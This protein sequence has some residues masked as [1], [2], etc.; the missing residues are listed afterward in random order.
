MF[1]EKCHDGKKYFAVFVIE[2]SKSTSMLS[3]L[4]GRKEDRIAQVERDYGA[5]AKG[6]GWLS[7]RK[8]SRTRAII[9]QAGV[10]D[11]I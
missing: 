6:R 8:L 7:T 3:T 4:I 10:N 1:E 2:A 9:I 11:A 5:W